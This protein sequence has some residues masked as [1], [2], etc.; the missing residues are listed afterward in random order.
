MYIPDSVTS[1]YIKKKNIIYNLSKRLSTYFSQLK[2]KKVDQT[3]IVVILQKVMAQSHEGTS[4]VKLTFYFFNIG[5]SYIG[6]LT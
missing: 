5:A 6:V 2:K 3:R 4:W 1:K